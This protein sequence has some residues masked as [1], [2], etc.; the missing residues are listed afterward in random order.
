MMHDLTPERRAEILA[1]AEE[2]RRHTAE[3]IDATLKDLSDARIA[4]LAEDA[5]FPPVKLWQSLSYDEKRA[6]RARNEQARRKL[7]AEREQAK[8]A[9]AAE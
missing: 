4:D 2:R 1:E 9:E 3:S 8:Q 7:V 5:V 6:Q